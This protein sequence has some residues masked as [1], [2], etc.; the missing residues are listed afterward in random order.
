M[1]D[2]ILGIVR[3]LITAGGVALVTKGVLDA[4]TANTAVGAVMTLLSVGWS[5]YEKRTR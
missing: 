1:K 3:H 4:A 5:V 2:M